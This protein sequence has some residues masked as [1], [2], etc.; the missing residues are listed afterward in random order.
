MSSEKGDGGTGSGDAAGRRGTGVQLHGA[1]AQPVQPHEERVEPAGVLGLRPPRPRRA[2][3]PGFL[4]WL[5][6]VALQSA[7]RARGRRCWSST[8][9]RRSCR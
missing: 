1:R 5:T 9:P 2:V 8:T 3:K 4:G 7:T 6:E